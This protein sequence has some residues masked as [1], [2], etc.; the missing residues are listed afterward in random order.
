[1][2][3]KSGTVDYFLLAAG[4]LTDVDRLVDKEFLYQVLEELPQRIQMN[5]IQKPIVLEATNNPGLEGYVPIDE[6]NITISTYTN[7]YRFVASIHSCASFRYADVI[8]YLM[9]AFQTSDVTYHYISETD[10]DTWRG[11]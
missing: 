8:E 11:K 2:N 5:A 3:D 1:M 10:F 7:K 4:Y 9:E 6:S